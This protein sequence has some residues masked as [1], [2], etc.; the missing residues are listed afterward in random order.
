M[1][2]LII[3]LKLCIKHGMRD[4]RIW[5]KFISWKNHHGTFPSTRWS[6]RAERLVHN[7]F[8]VVLT[9][10]FNSMIESTFQKT[11]YFFTAVKKDHFSAF[12]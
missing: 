3:E 6:W 4:D 1:E 12:L 8:Y 7:I 10:V 11:Q 5:V 2:C 9:K